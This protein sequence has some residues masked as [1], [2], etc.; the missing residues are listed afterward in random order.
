MWGERGM[1]VTAKQFFGYAMMPRV[2][3][4]MRELFGSGFGHVAFYMAQIYALVRLLPANHAYLNPENIGR[5]GVA[6]VVLEAARNLKFDRRHIDQIGVFGLILLAMALLLAQ[7][8]LL[9]FA[10]FVQTAKAAVPSI[11]D[12]F[13]TPVPTNDVAFVLLDRVFGIPGL[14]N[15]CVSTGVTPCLKSN[16]VDPFPFQY[17]L[18]LHDMLAFYSMG[19]AVIG[20][21]IFMYYAV[22]ITVETAQTGTPFGRRFNHV[23][24]PV[25][26]IVALGLLI[27]ISLGFNGAQL[28][29]L[30]M[31]K[32]GS[33]LATNG[34]TLFVDVLVTR[35]VHQAGGIA[36][37][38]ATGAVTA[39]T[40]VANPQ[41]PKPNE[42]L[43]FY[44]VLATCVQAYETIHNIPIDAYLVKASGASA[45]QPLLGSDWAAANTFFENGPIVVVFGHRDPALHTTFKAQ[46]R[47][48]CG[49]I[50]FAPGDVTEPGTVT[51]MTGYY[52][53][54][55]RQPWRNIA[56]D[57]AT[58]LMA[59]AN[60]PPPSGAQQDYFYF[61]ALNII[62]LSLT[63]D[64]PNSMLPNADARDSIMAWWTNQVGTV[65]TAGVAQ[66]LSDTQ[67]IAK[68]N[69]YGWGGAAIWYNKIAQL[70][71]SLLGAVSNLPSVSQWPEVM[72]YVS[73][74]K[75]KQDKG[76]LA[77]QIYLPRL[78]DGAEI[79]FP[80]GGDS[81]ISYALYEA[82]KIWNDAALTE[83][84]PGVGGAINAHPSKNAFVDIVNAFFGTQGLYNMRD[85]ANVHPLAQLVIMGKYLLMTSVRNLSI[86]AA[87]SAGASWVIKILSLPDGSEDMAQAIVSLMWTIGSMTISIGFILYYVIPFMPF[88]YFFFQVGG[89][90]KA[91][92]E[93]MVGLP[94]WAL[95]HIRID[96]DGLP[97]SAAM[98]GY[99]LIFEIFLRP[100]LTIFGLIG[101]ISIFAAQ[102]QV[103]N[104]IFELVVS[105]VT[106]FDRQ[107]ATA[108]T[109][110]VGA[111]SFV[112]GG[113]DQLFY[114]VIY[115]IIVYMMGTASFKLVYLIPNNMLRWMGSNVDSFGEIA[116]DAP[117]HLVSTVYGSSTV[118]TGQMRQATQMA[119]GTVGSTAAPKKT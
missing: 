5:F 79:V 10:L 12:F 112:R 15:S 17:H 20:L 53:Q 66:M 28:L 18:A 3:P 59:A 88:V 41:Y 117:E 13:I 102:V 78:S 114:T 74:E 57:G 50:T 30:Y 84:N 60:L 92:F 8:F 34:W 116:K 29:T 111:F 101:G 73:N 65:I 25:R 110:G 39:T 61:A 27:P 87:G 95:A 113:I 98:S 103:L 109:T 81:R 97:G 9:G 56:T 45:S 63:P 43:R 77:D 64:S 91:I 105:N 106:G 4:M 86:G 83:Y 67:W 72:E 23:W 52:E 58:S 82:Y 71:G 99:F 32:W 104:S 47:P 19:I 94:L 89:W 90:V 6:H 107:A 62:N 80:K 38:P 31:A 108:L 115:V 7:L 93:A 68:L 40:M 11:G 24:A 44:T 85:N 119:L 55:I 1:K 51:I 100:I 70:N 2:I 37:D 21:L 35:T 26:M 36:I 54:L 75:T 33:S 22:A 118:I 46:I 76:T 48:Y 14:Y 49:Q 96:G 69:D 16:V 42:L